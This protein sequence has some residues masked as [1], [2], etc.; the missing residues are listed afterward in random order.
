MFK[1]QTF[2]GRQVLM[3]KTRRSAC[4]LKEQIL[5]WSLCMCESWPVDDKSYFWYL[6]ITILLFYKN[7]GT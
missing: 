3:S 7:G 4:V 5:C 6:L 2:K 1:S